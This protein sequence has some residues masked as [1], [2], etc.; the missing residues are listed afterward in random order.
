MS[1]RGWFPILITSVDFSRRP[2]RC[3][4]D[5]GNTVSRRVTVIIATG[6]QAR[7]LG[8]GVGA[9]AAGFGVSACATCDGFSLSRQAGGRGRRRQYT[10]VEEAL[11]LTHHAA[12]VTLIHRRDE[13]RAD[14]TNQ[15]RLF[16]SPKVKT[17]WDSVVEEIT[18]AGQPATVNGVRLRNLRTD[19]E[20]RLELD[21]VFVAIGHTPTT[22]VFQGQVAMDDEGYILT[23]PGSTRTS[24]AGVFAAGDV[25][26]K[27]WRQAVTAAGTGCMAALEV[28]KW[29]AGHGAESALAAE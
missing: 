22:S 4:G 3:H 18:S 15:R 2:F 13:L 25:Q 10:A 21:G 12:E 27:V 1:A 20:S 24:R 5:S 16:A 6:A 11:F 9:A 8:L 14:K 7:W 28:E 17:V 23:P 29:L 19:A 26:D